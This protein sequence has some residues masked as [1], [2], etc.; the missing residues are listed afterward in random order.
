VVIKQVLSLILLPGEA[1]AF[2]WRLLDPGILDAFG[3]RSAIYFLLLVALFG[4]VTVIGWFGANLTFP[5][6]RE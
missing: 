2:V 5:V 1:A 4:V 3:L 6:E